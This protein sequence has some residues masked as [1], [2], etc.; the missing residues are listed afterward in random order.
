MN[1]QQAF[2]AARVFTGNHRCVSQHIQGTQSNIFAMT[3][4]SRHNIQSSVEFQGC[5]LYDG[6]CHHDGSLS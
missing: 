4:G 6:G 5:L 2:G 3:N 1:G